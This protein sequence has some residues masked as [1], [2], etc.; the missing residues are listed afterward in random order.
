MFELDKNVRCDAMFPNYRCVNPIYKQ[1]IIFTQIFHIYFE[2]NVSKHFSA[3]LSLQ[4]TVNAFHEI[5]H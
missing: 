5:V 3:N 2:I 1:N 4:Q